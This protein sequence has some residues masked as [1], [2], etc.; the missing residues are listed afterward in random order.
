M[1]AIFAPFSAGGSTH[2]AVRS[3]KPQSYLNIANQLGVPAEQVL[4]ISDAKAECQAAQ[5]G[6][7]R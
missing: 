1:L 5:H 6:H 3:R 7:A 4:F 2:A